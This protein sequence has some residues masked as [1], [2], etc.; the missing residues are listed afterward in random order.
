MNYNFSKEKDVRSSQTFT[1]KDAINA[2][3]DTYKLRGKLNEAH[4]VNSWE[5]LMGRPIASRTKQVF[6]KDRKLYVELNSAPLKNELAM[7]RS[8]I[9]E[10]FNRDLEEKAI[11]E[12]IFL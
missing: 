10:I 1:M 7:S 11:E 5:R 4:I 6:L 2:L 9:V 8:K 12:V 3:L